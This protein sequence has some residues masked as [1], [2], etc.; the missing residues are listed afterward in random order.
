MDTFLVGGAVRDKLLGLEIIDRD[1]VVVGSTPQQM[2]AMGFKPVG[3]DIP[4]FIK[5]SSGEEYALARTE[6]K[7]AKGYQGFAFNTSPDIT[8]EDDL[9]RRDLTIN[10]MAQAEDG[11]IID[12]F[13]GQTDLKSKVLRHVSDAFVEDPVRILRVARFAARFG[14]TV[15]EDTMKLMKIM[16]KN[17]EVDALVAE[18]VWAE[19]HKALLC[20]FPRKFIEI[21]YECGALEKILPEIHALFGIP[22]PEQYHPEIDTGIHTLMVLDQA[23]QLS[24]EPIVRFA[25]LMHD[26]G[27]AKTP[28]EKWPQHIGHEQLGVPVIQALCQRLRVP[29]KFRELACIVSENH[30]KM[31]RLNE[32][33]STTVLKLLEST[34]SLRDEQ[35]AKHFVLACEADAKGRTGFENR[36]YP[37][38][39]LFFNY[40]NA[41]ISVDSQAIAK[42]YDNGIA[43]KEAIRRSRIQAIATAK[44]TA[45]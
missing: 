29:T 16:V 34:G 18:R 3:K 17:G 9:S 23:C 28:K 20:E 39:E 12:P 22:Q 27:K 5:P 25:A 36:N 15:A 26:L 24:S 21:L 19:L 31:H 43:I 40:L 2:T 10:A 38:R 7:T 44:T 41:A 32:L 30:L 45:D 37:Q 11:S 4:V 1:W 6:R 14:F 35:R 33:K 42:Q 13:D 8:L